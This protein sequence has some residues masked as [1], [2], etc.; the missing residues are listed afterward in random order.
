MRLLLDHPPLRL[1]VQFLNERVDSLHLLNACVV[2]VCGALDLELDLILRE[3]GLV[4][5]GDARLLFLDVCVPLALELVVGLSLG[6]HDL[7]SA[8]VADEFEQRL[9]T[10]IRFTG[11][12]CCFYRY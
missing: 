1:F 10:T 2:L 4:L 11:V 9:M 7:L 12:H 6:L 8:L 5:G 3:P